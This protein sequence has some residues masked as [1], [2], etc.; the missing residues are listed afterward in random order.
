MEAKAPLRDVVELK[1]HMVLAVASD[2]INLY[3]GG[4]C[5]VY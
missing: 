5:I 1:I 2:L 4:P 3:L